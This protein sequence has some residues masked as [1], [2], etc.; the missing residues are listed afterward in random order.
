MGQ[1]VQLIGC[2]TKRL[3]RREEKDWQSQVARMPP[4]ARSCTKCNHQ[5]LLLFPTPCQ[6]RSWP[7]KHAMRSENTLLTLE[8]LMI[9]GCQCRHRVEI[10]YDRQDRPSCKVCA[11]KQRDFS[12][13]LRRTTRFTHTKCDFALKLLKFYTFVKFI[14]KSL[15]KLLILHLHCFF[16][17][18]K[19]LA[20][21]SSHVNF[22]INLKSDK[23]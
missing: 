3:A 20:R 16:Q 15:L 12:H 4:L 8:V 18:V 22:L 11:G 2:V 7:R 10:C 19:F 21:K 5:S 6:W 14:Q 9:C 17:C 13:I 1:W 23:T